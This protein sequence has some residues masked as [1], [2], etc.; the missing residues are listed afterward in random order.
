MRAII[1]QGQTSKK[2][3]RSGGVKAK[4]KTIGPANENALEPKTASA[5]VTASKL[6]GKLNPP[7]SPDIFQER[8]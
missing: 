3:T 4:R 6:M 2:S 1:S 8:K 5:S 7:K